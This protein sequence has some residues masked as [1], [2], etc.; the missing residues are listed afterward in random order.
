M[1]R[2]NRELIE[3]VHCVRGVVKGFEEAVYFGQFKNSRSRPGDGRQF[4]VAIPLHGFLKA[5]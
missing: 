2:I 1:E 4:D 5:V 3:A